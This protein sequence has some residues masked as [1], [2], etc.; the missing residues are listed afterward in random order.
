MANQWKP[1]SFPNGGR[2]FW[3]ANSTHLQPWLVGIDW[4]FR[5][6]YPAPDPY[7]SQR[8]CRTS[9]SMIFPT[10]LPYL[11][12]F[13][14]S[15]TSRTNSSPAFFRILGLVVGSVEFWSTSITSTTFRSFSGDASLNLRSSS[16]EITKSALTL[17]LLYEEAK[18]SSLSITSS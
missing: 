13:S 10:Q 6:P 15:R 16:Q 18:A 5:S 9:M 4:A 12:E 17:I 2:P 1:V 14:Q 8:P 11:L 3:I 7:P